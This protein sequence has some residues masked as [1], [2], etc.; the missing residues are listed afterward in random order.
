MKSLES[1]GAGREADLLSAPSSRPGGPP[2]P[3]F[4]GFESSN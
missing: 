4:S 3:E 2:F 1:D